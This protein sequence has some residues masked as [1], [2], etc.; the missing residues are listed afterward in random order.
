M[1]SGERSKLD[2]KVRKCIFFGFETRVNDNRLWDP[3]SKK[4]NISK[5]VVFDESYLLRKQE[6]RVST[7]N[8]KEKQVVE[9][10]FDD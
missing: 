8:Q 7:N 3:V 1:Q 9:V 4:K 5:D 6:N 10:K 2:Q